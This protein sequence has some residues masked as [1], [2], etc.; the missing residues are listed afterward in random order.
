MDKGRPLTLIAQ[1]LGF[2][3]IIVV[4]GGGGDGVAVSGNT[5][6][7]GQIRDVDGL[8]IF[9]HTVATVVGGGV[10]S[11]EVQSIGISLCQLAGV[12]CCVVNSCHVKFSFSELQNLP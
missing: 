3:S 1:N 5:A 10:Q 7:G 4:T 8:A 9:A 2:P 12:L 11:A 6:S